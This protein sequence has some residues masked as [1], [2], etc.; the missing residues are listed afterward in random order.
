[1]KKISSRRGRGRQNPGERNSGAGRGFTLIEILIT[2]VL[3][4]LLFSL[5]YSTFFS[6]SRVTAELQNKMRNSETV[7]RFLNKFNEE[8][9]CM[10]YEAED[11]D[12][13]FDMRE[14]TFITR[15]RIS[16]YPVKITYSVEPSADNKNTLLRTQE[17][18]LDGYSFAF[19]VLKGA[20]EIDFLFYNGESWDYSA[21][22]DKVTAAAI[23]MDYEGERL[24]FPVKIYRDKTDDEKE[25][26]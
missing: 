1:M 16:P 26:K 7:F 12:T 21:E 3:V 9:K 17:N 24:F 20:D 23:E 22:R 5:I 25:T 13:V 18:L 15:D 19:P 6:I 8:V 10:I 14:L 2:T 11:E 4:F